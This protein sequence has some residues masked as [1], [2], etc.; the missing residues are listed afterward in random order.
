M[1]TKHFYLC[2]LLLVLGTA[3][4]WADKY[5]C[6]NYYHDG[7]TR[8]TSLAE[9]I[10]PGVQFMIYNTTIDVGDDYTG[11]LYNNGT[12]LALDKSK[13]RDRY[14]YNEN[15]LYTMEE[16]DAD[17]DGINDYYAIKSVANGTYVG[18]DGVAS[19]KTPQPLYIKDWKSAKDAWNCA[20]VSSEH[21]DYNIIDKDNLKGDNANSTNAFAISNAATGTDGKYWGGDANA[22]ITPADA[23]LPFAFYKVYEETSGSYL[24]DLHI[25]S[26]CDVYSAQVIWGYVQSVSDIVVNPAGDANKMYLLDGDLATSVSTAAGAGEHY[27]QFNLGEATSSIYLFMQRSSTDGAVIPANVTIQAS[28]NGTD[29]WVTIDGNPENDNDN[30]FATGLAT[31][32]SFTKLVS[33]N[34]S[35]QYIRVANAAADA[36]L[37]LS[38]IYILPD[39]KKTEDAFGYFA[40]LQQPRCPVYL[41]GAPQHFINAIEDY[42]TNHPEVKT[43]SGVPLAGNKYRIYADAYN[44]TSYENKEISLGTDTLAINP[45]GS[46]HSLSGDEAKK[47]EWYC[48]Q[49][50]N[51]KLVFRN[52][53]AASDGVDGDL[54]LANNGTMSTTPYEW[55]MSTFGTSR[56][57]V[58]LR[59]NAG[60]Y[61]AISNNGSW[62]PDI[63]APQHQN[64]IPYTK[65]TTSKDAEGNEVTETVTVDKGVCTDFVFIPVKVSADIEKKIT[66]T[67]NEIAKRNTVFKYKGVVYN[68]PFS[69]MF[70]KGEE[71]PELT[72][73]C[74]TIHSYADTYVDNKPVTDLDKK[75]ASCTDNVV[76]FDFDKIAD[77]DVLEVKLTIKKPFEMGNGN[78]Y[79]I[80]SLRKQS[81]PQQAPS[82]PRR[83]DNVPVSPGGQGQ[84]STSQGNVYYAKFESRAERMSLIA[85]SQDN[86]NY[87]HFTAASLF[88]FEPTEDDAIDEYYS[89]NIR[90]AITPMKCANTEEW[91]E[92]GDIWH[93]QPN[94]AG[95]HAGYAISLD[96]LK[97]KN[98]PNGWCTN[99][100]DGDII[101]SYGVEDE[102]AAWDFVK[103]DD[104]NAIKLLQDYIASV[105]QSV[106]DSIDKVEGRDEAKAELYKA[107]VDGIHTNSTHANIDVATLVGLSQ[108]IHM[109]QHEISYALQP[110]PTVS[111]M[112][113]KGESNDFESPHWYYI[114][115]VKSEDH[116]ARYTAN[117]SLMALDQIADGDQ[118]GDKDYGLEHMFYLE[119]RKV[120]ETIGENQF[121][122]V[123]GNALTV[124][125]YLQVDIHNFMVPDTTVVSKNDAVV[126]KTL[127]LSPKEGK[128][129]IASGFTL[130]KDQAWR[131]SFEYDLEN[132]SYNAHGLTLLSSS[133]DP[134]KDTYN[135]EFQVYLKADKSV[136]VK[137]N[138][139][140]DDYR[141][142]H[143][144]EN[145]SKIK[146]V[147]TYSISEIKFDIY[148]AKGEVETLT[149]TNPAMNDVTVLTTMLPAEGAKIKMLLMEYVKSFN[150]QQQDV[151]AGENASATTDTK[152]EYDTWY[153]LP[154]SNIK[155]PGLAIVSG[156]VN[157]NNFGWANLAGANDSIFSDAGTSDNATW[158]FQK[159]LEF[160]DHVAQ[161]LEKYAASDCVIYNEELARLV[162]LIKKNASYINAIDYDDEN[163]YID[164]HSDEYFF[165]EIYEAIKNYD[166][167]MPD[168]LKK[169]KPGKFYTVRPAYGNS[170]L[171]VLANEYNTMVQKNSLEEVVD[172]NTHR[173]SRIVWFFDG[174]EE[175]DGFYKLDNTLSLNSLHTQSNTYVFADDSVL[176]NDVN[177]K[178][179]TLNPVGG[180][181]VRLND[182]INNLRHK[183]MGD[184]ILV[185]NAGTMSYGYASTEFERTGTQKDGSTI[186]ATSFNEFNEILL[187]ESQKTTVSVTSN[188][189]YKGTTEAVTEGILCPNVNGGSESNTSATTATPIELAFTYN[190]LPS[191][192]TSFNNIGLHIHALNGGSKYQQNADNKA[193]Q[194]NIA[195]SV[196]TDGGDTFTEF[197]SVSDIDIAAG[198]GQSEVSVHKVWNIVKSDEAQDFAING[199]LV[200]KLTIQKGT[201]NNG[202]FFGLSNVILSA[203]GDTWYIEEIPDAEK[204]YIYHETKANKAGLGSLMLGYT[205]KIPTGISAFYPIKGNDFTDRHLTLKSYGEPQ[206]DV[207]LLPACTPSIIKVADGDKTAAYRFY[208]DGSEVADAADKATAADDKIVIDGSLYKKYQE[209]AC[210]E[211]ADK[212]SDEATLIGEQCNVYMYLQTGDK[213]VWV[214]EN[215]KA[216]GTKTGNNDEGGHVHV[217]ANRA[218]LVIGKSKVAQTASL[219]LRFNGSTTTGIDDI[220]NDYIR[221]T[222]N[223]GVKGIFDLQGRKL[224]KITAPGMYIVDGEKVLVE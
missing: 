69:R 56:H 181:I 111:Y 211:T 68:L 203:E 108:K 169:P 183:A 100:A 62:T 57:G 96:V 144:Q 119:G 214:Y 95:N 149:P 30:S 142:Y 101:L 212:S 73:Q 156:G 6:P 12:R 221:E 161:L 146:V 78:L 194:W 2:L 41:K 87:D 47:Y 22:F 210:Y 91:N 26:R 140:Y 187:G 215:Y 176:L 173:D 145:Y 171:R 31:D 150:W 61:L 167:P 192:F 46:Y 82:M 134:A 98:E 83:A 106:K 102:G 97:A 8:Y 90:S 157:D 138:N 170:D 59:D 35:Y 115:N 190:N 199:S 4:V 117:H 182:G 151:S 205:A 16:C 5:Y 77:G 174:T 23:A 207:R 135:K 104:A 206:D 48:E 7:N 175:E 124:D 20:D 209:V 109:I 42:N 14:V 113:K 223:T 76:S 49:T 196:S 24:Q 178:S 132:V 155:Y 152:D 177:P 224:H 218:Y 67:A 201:T 110:L 126:P 213:L 11:F 81:V 143:T 128:Q 86:I 66:F 18:F 163:T 51:G 40:K 53:Y 55:T 52:V 168:E 107:I 189:D 136:V 137:L 29:G 92:S 129:E 3:N 74:P 121:D 34:G 37:A 120:T 44:G 200:V 158:Q 195:V 13:D 222:V 58:P 60:K 105:T 131:I 141:V 114:W 63:T 27:F 19:H 216:D 125:E 9:L 172:G 79:L 217:A 160:D 193:R 50:V 112:E 33:L 1:R 99:H 139:T 71:L 159:I 188:Y 54:Y 10:A 186:T 180:C 28:A 32:I 64:I 88:Y 38:E 80:R 164:G 204:Q 130:S 17:G 162:R 75:P 198:I 184:S 191:T 94:V 72:L 154:S 153:V 70:I 84:V 133:Q 197:G 15:F 147:I 202:C 166:G 122:K 25:F 219:S 43:L 179:I 185:G 208:Y 148:N 220:T 85:S 116:Y 127:N 45:A 21:Y 118:D 65:T 103:V 39:N 165:N 36:Q 93:V 89:V 123:A